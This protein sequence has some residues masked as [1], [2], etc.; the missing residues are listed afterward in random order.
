MSVVV[1][2]VVRMLVFPVLVL[3]STPDRRR[4]TNPAQDMAMAPHMRMGMHRTTVTMFKK[5]SH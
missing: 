2:V 4:K 3:V 5:I 1:G